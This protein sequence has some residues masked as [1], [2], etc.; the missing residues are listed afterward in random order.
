MR[1][2]TSAGANFYS[3]GSTV[4]GLVRLLPLELVHTL[5]PPLLLPARLYSCL[6]S[7]GAWPRTITSATAP[8]WCLMSTSSPTW[9]RQTSWP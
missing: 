6:Q 2:L 8:S 7:W 5:K 4:H 1:S 3:A 9:G